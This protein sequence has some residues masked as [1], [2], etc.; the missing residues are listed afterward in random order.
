MFSLLP[1]WIGRFLF[2]TLEFDF[3]L[4]KIYLL[5]FVYKTKDCIAQM[6]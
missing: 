2:P 6:L 3:N 5:Y 4:C 1:L